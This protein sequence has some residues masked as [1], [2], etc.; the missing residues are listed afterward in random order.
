MSGALLNMKAF[1]ALGVPVF[2]GGRLLLSV[3]HG[4][5]GV[6]LSPY[7]NQHASSGWDAEKGEYSDSAK[8]CYDDAA[9]CNLDSVRIPVCKPKFSK[10]RHY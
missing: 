6:P 10:S 7:K 5:V 9:S 1:H 2:G 4:P 8:R 3:K